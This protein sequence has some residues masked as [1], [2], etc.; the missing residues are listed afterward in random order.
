ML[1]EK[2]SNFLL[3]MKR[4]IKSFTA[5]LI[6]VDDLII[7]VD[8]LFEIDMLKHHMNRNFKIKDLGNLRY[9]LGLEI[10]RTTLGIIISRRKY[11]LDLLEDVGLIAG[12][13]VRTP[14]VREQPKFPKMT[15]YMVTHMRIGD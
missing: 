12:E 3:C 11:T 6:Y 10:A 8:N 1:F 15:C 5:I 2:L 7:C 9:F 14:M 13:P 4:T